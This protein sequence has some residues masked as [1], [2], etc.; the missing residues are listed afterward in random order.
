MLLGNQEM[1]PGHFRAMWFLISLMLM[2]LASSVV[3]NRMYIVSIIT[4]VIALLLIKIGFFTEGS[5]YFQLKT[6][7][8]SYQFFA[9]GHALRINPKVD[10]L[11]RL[12]KGTLLVV[13]IVGTSLLSILGWKYVGNVNLFRGKTGDNLPCFLVV[14]YG[15]SYLS[16]KV[17]ELFGYDSNNVVRTFSLGTLFIV[18]THQTLI[19]TIAHFISY[20]RIILPIITTVVILL[21][22][23]PVIILLEKY[24]P[25]LIGKSK[26]R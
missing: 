11:K 18:C 25:L 16:L 2:R 9:F 21:V 6:T 12:N 17:I 13:I 15:L 3:K 23:Y 20:D 4:F 19:M 5:D 24:C 22:S 7:M 8:L 10:V 1:L 26:I 14:A